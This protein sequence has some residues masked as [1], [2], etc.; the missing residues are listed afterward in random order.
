MKFIITES[1]FIHYLKESDRHRTGRINVNTHT[2]PDI[3]EEWE[4]YMMVQEIH[5]TKEDFY[6]LDDDGG[7]LGDRIE[8][9]ST[10]R[11]EFVPLNKIDRYEFDVSDNR[12]EM[13]KEKIIDNDGKYPP[14]VLND[15]YE[16]IDG[17]HR[18]WAIYELGYSKILSYIGV[19]E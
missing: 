10:Y 18:C 11:L 3:A 2:Y 15:N 6:G 4:V 8:E 14:I 1:Q 19:E 17:T 13:V 9:Y 16:I 7:D 5:H 12:V